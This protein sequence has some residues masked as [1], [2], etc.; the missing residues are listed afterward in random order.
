MLNKLQNI[1]LQMVKIN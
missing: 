1:I